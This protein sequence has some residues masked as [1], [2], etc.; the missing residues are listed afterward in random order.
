MPVSGGSTSIAGITV[1]SPPAWR[2]ARARRSH[3]A[4]ARTGSVSGLS[5]DRKLVPPRMRQVGP[6]GDMRYVLTRRSLLLAPARID[7]AFFGLEL[8]GWNRAQKGDEIITILL[9]HRGDVGD[10]GVHRRR[11]RR[12]VGPCARG[13]NL[14]QLIV[15]VAPEAGFFAAGQIRGEALSPR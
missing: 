9:G 6:G 11:Q 1:T 5:L 14:L 2:I 8:H 15:G 10:H 7:L 4:R 3:S 13:Q 12:A